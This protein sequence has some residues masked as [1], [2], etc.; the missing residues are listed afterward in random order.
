MIYGLLGEH[1]THSYSKLIH[2]KICDYRYDLLEMN[3][4]QLDEF[5]KKKAFYGVNV[6]I[7][8]KQTVIPYLDELDHSAKKIGAVNTILNE[9]GTL[10]GYNTD[11]FGF[12]STLEL[13]HISI[14]GK[15]V[16][17]LGNGGAA[18][19]VCAALSDLEAAQ[20]IKVKKNISNETI[21]Y[22]ECYQ[23]HIDAQVIVNTSP[24]GMYP[25]VNESPID[26]SLFSTLESVVDVIYNPLKTRLL[27]EAEEKGCQVADGLIMLVAQAVKAIEIFTHKKLDSSIISSL[28]H[29]I[30]KDKYNLV[31]IG[32]PGSGKSTV[33]HLVAQRLNMKHLELDQM[34][35]DR[36]QMSIEDYFALNGEEA[37]RKKETEVILDIAKETNCV[38]SCGGG[39][40]KNAENMHALKMNGIVFFLD[41]DVEQLAISQGRP[42]STSR[43]QVK[44]L[45]DERIEAYHHY[46]DTTIENNST[47]EQAVFEC[48]K[49]IEE[50]L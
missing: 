31:F 42:L 22:E 50:V 26:L 20:I 14:K 28:T 9:N 16:I 19:A 48:L 30:K 41:R 10:K 49:V 4:E 21:T 32:M 24:V 5:L 23:N 36:L 17:V 37:F 15:K 39:V 6:T 11:Y 45:Y 2:E 44:K 13:N 1:L 7:P 25:N 3:L 34:I 18:K 8:Y 47:I 43:Q 40:I 33:S 35:V 38:I 12:L 27:V 29:E 46:A